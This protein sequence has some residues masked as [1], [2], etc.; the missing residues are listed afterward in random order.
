MRLLTDSL[1]AYLDSL[2]LISVFGFLVFAVMLFLLGTFTYVVVGAGFVRYA[3]VLAGAIPIADAI[4]LVIV[5]VVSLFSVSFLATAVTL[6]VKMRR[7]MDD[8]QFTKLL[9]KFPR[10]VLRLMLAWGLIGVV[11]FLIGL[12]FNA[13]GLPGFLTALAMLVL[14]AFFIFL[15]QSMILHDKEFVDALKDSASYCVKKPLGVIVYYVIT[16]AM[17]AMLLVIDV[18]LG[19][20]TIFWLPVLVDTLLLF[21]FVIPYLEVLKANLYLT[22]YRLL[23]SGLK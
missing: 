5:A 13:V 18:G 8:I 20:T 10:Y 6:I 1:A 3:D 11:T 17:L 14:W 19:Q 22:R 23:L 2:S 16:I 15:P 4:M 9:V 12:V 7:S 21:L